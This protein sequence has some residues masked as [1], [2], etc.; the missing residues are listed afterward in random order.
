MKLLFKGKF[1][2]I[3]WLSKPSGALA[4]KEYVGGI[5]YNPVSAEEIYT[6][7]SALDELATFG[8]ATFTAL[9]YSADPADGLSFRDFVL[10][11]R[12]FIQFAETLGDAERKSCV[13]LADLEFRRAFAYAGELYITQ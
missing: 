1:A 4:L 6:L 9:G 7:P 2:E 3:D 10:F 5:P 13:D 11:Q 8:S 12:D